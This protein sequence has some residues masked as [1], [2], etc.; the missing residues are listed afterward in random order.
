MRGSPCLLGVATQHDT[1][2]SRQACGKGLEALGQARMINRI[3]TDATVRSA[4][5]LSSSGGDSH[6]LRVARGLQWETSMAFDDVLD[7]VGDRAKGKDGNPKSSIRPDFIAYD[8][9]SATG[10][11]RV[12]ELKF[13]SNADIVNAYRDEVR[14]AVKWWR[15]RVGADRVAGLDVTP[16][17]DEFTMCG[18]AMVAEAEDLDGPRAEEERQAGRRAELARR[19]DTRRK[20]SSCACRSSTCAPARRPPPART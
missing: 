1:Y 12:A 4:L 10:Q 18:N 6:G 2:T 20:G 15:T 19:G 13:Y 9:T 8:P 14:A 11:M 7:P 3:N 5:G 16:Y 17:H